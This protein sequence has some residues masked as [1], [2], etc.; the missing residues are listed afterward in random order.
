MRHPILLALLLG[1]GASGATAQEGPA[2]P[3]PP[4]T[5]RIRFVS[6]LRSEVDLGKKEGFFGKLKRSLTGEQQA[7]FAVRRPFDVYSFDGTHV[8]V[9][10]GM[11]AGILLFDWEKKEARTLGR[12][13]PGG[14]ARPMGLGG[15]GTG[16]V[17]VTDPGTGR[18][19]VLSPEGAFERAFGGRDVLYNPVDVAVDGVVGRVY[20]VDSY[21]H[22]VVVFDVA[23]AVIG[24]LGKQEVTLADRKN[25]I[26]H[27]VDAPSMG[28]DEAPRQH[29]QAGITS[30]GKDLWQNRGSEPGEFRYPVAVAVGPDGMV[31]VSDQ[32]NFRVQVFDRLGASVRQVGQAGT[33]PGSFARPKGVAVDSE[34]HLYVADAAFSNIQVFDPDG[35]LLLAFGSLGHGLGEHWMPLGLCIDLQ[36]RIYVADR[37]NNRASVYQYLPAPASAVVEGPGAS[38]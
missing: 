8:F 6:E 12:D 20:V 11:S 31:Y 4:E 5:P 14:L 32:M 26:S 9:S 19:I 29:A 27:T 36:D 28:G 34:G 7:M 23:G 18:V 22:Q 30:K 33:T 25:Q 35:T 2:W 13:V 16:R 15:D 3:A 1:L 38:Q 17:Y 21:L 24:R 10:D 37:Y